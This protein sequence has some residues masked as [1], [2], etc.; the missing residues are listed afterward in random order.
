[1][2][3]LLFQKFTRWEKIV[4]SS[5]RS[6]EEE[7]LFRHQLVTIFNTLVNSRQ[8]MHFKLGN[9]EVNWVKIS[10]ECGTARKKM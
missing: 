5:T 1:M 10:H 9:S 8:I 6:R 4:S 2:F 3:E 7:L